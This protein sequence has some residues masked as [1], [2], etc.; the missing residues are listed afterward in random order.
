M[1]LSLESFEGPALL[2]QG[3]AI[4]HNEA[5]TTRFHNA[6]LLA[7]FAPTSHELITQL[8]N[9]RTPS[10]ISAPRNDSAG[11][12]SLTYLPISGP[13]LPTYIV[14]LSDADAEPQRP[15]IHQLLMVGQLAAGVAHDANNALTTVIGRLLRIR[16]RGQL[17][18]VLSQ[19]LDIIESAT[20]NAATILKRLQE[21]SKRRKDEL[22]LV[23]L[24][25]LLEE[26]SRFVE[27]QVPDGVTLEV[28]VKHTPDVVSHRQDLME[29]LLNLTGNAMD[30]VAERSGTVTLRVDLSNGQPT[31]IVQDNGVGI[32]DDI[33]ARMFDPFFST[34]GEKGTGLGLSM[35]RDILEG[36]GIELN[37]ESKLG[38]GTAFKL[39]FPK[40]EQTALGQRKLKK[41]QLNVMVVDDDVFVSEMI[42]ELIQD[43][44]H[45]VHAVNSAQQALDRVSQ[46]P[47]DLLLTDLDLP[48]T[49]GWKLAQQIRAKYPDVI[50]GM[51][52]G[53]PLS[54]EERAS[55][56]QTVDFILN[57]PFTMREL[58]LA[59]DRIQIVQEPSKD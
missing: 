19:D 23:P 14:L 42:T 26:I 34:K 35:T 58:K 40:T 20:R 49:D 8:L 50:I 38:Q 52:T 37:W 12:L 4:T 53:W 16:T 48:E 21:F 47:V 7:L 27:T 46:K 28:D 31:I 5:Y 13:E 30:A 17:T 15:A 9:S 44:G 22:E 24:A 6:S 54:L 18:P 36:H 56:S 59:L 3:S 11:A 41:N 1:N 2:C 29:V 33:A 55:S 45:I 32:P 39:I 51:V 57:K 10:T 25:E 43:Q